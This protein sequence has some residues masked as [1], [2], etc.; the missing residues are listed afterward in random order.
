MLGFRLPVVV[1]VDLQVSGIVSAFTFKYYN[2]QSRID[3][4]TPDGLRS[5]P[6]MDLQV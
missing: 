1:G 3:L 6:S 2:T 4:K 5:V